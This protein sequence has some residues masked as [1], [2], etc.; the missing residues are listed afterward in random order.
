[1]II[2]RIGRVVAL[3]LLS[4]LTAGIVRTAAVLLLLL[5]I[6]IMIIA[7]IGRVVALLLLSFL[8]ADGIVRTA[9]L[10]AAAEQADGP[11]RILTLHG[12]PIGYAG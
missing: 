2:A 9:A 5:T 11:G 12:L 8:T 1:M 4:F 3:L 10:Q 6:I 7:R